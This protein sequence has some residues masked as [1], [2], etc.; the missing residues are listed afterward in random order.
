[1]RLT[2][3]SIF[4]EHQAFEAAEVLF[5]G[6]VKPIDIASSTC[7][8]DDSSQSIIVEGA[9]RLAQQHDVGSAC[10]YLRQMGLEWRQDNIFRI[11]LDGPYVETE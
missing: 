5:T 3:A 2:L 1:M 9:I 10:G 8:M 6:L 7:E 11:I 4:R